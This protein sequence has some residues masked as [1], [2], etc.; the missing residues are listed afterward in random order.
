MSKYQV[1]DKVIV[2][3]ELYLN[4]MYY[5]ENSEYSNN[6]VSEMQEF[7]GKEIT[8]VEIFNNECYLIEE[9][10]RTWCWTDEMFEGLAEEVRNI[11]KNNKELEKPKLTKKQ[12]IEILGYDFDYIEEN[13]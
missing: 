3:K 2:K 10:G 8:I 5:M 13:K 11:E 12:L 4:K 1:G 9:D 6:V 7:E